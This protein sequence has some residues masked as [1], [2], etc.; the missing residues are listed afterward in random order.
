[1][2]AEKICLLCDKCINDR[3][4]INIESIATGEWLKNAVKNRIKKNKEVILAV[5]QDIYD[6]KFVHC[7]CVGKIYKSLI[8]L[9]SDDQQKF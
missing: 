1:M 4:K 2:L 3:D 5:D 6:E 9:C 8:K 7:S